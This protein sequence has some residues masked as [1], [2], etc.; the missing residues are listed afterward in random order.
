M[1][2]TQRSADVSTQHGCNISC[3]FN[4]ELSDVLVSCCQ[5]VYCIMTHSTDIV[6]HKLQ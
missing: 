4:V 2:T 1:T 5:Y 6:I 3:H